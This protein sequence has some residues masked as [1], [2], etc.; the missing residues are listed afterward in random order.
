MVASVCFI[1]RYNAETNQNMRQ[2]LL[3][4]LDISVGD[5]YSPKRLK[6]KSVA[7][8]NT[9]ICKYVLLVSNCIN[10]FC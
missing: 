1:F 2:Y 7:D 6:S 9:C 4:Q 3:D 10:A 5:Q 8:V